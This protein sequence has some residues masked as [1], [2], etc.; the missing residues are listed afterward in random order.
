MFAALILISQVVSSSSQLSYFHRLDGEGH[1]VDESYV[2]CQADDGSCF[3]AGKVF[4]NPGSK[5]D[6]FVQKVSPTGKELWRKV[7][8]P[9]QSGGD[10]EYRAGHLSERFWRSDIPESIAQDHE[11]NVY[12]AGETTLDTSTKAMRSGRSAGTA[13]V[14]Y[15]TN[16]RLRFAKSFDDQANPKIA[17][18]KAG[19]VIM[20]CESGCTKAYLKQRNGGLTLEVRS[21]STTDG[22]EIS[23]L[24]FGQDSP[25]VAIRALNDGT[26]TL[27]AAAGP[28]FDNTEFL[29]KKGSPRNPTAWRRYTFDSKMA[30][31]SK[32]EFDNSKDL[33]RGKAAISPNGDIFCLDGRPDGSDS[34]TCWI[35]DKLAWRQTL[36]SQRIRY[37][38]PAD[39]DG[40]YHYLHDRLQ[41]GKLER[42]ISANSETVFVA[43]GPNKSTGTVWQV[44]AEAFRI[45]SGQPFGMYRHTLTTKSGESFVLGMV[46]ASDSSLLVGGKIGNDATPNVD[47]WYGAFSLIPSK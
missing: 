46:V 29:Y 38:N 30:V 13:L 36:A 4:S 12:I 6:F 43:G 31:V 11:G 41:I 14:S 24:V 27:V 47:A 16:G 35:H 22:R 25:P 26:V 19:T 17:I 3:F 7:Y 45:S 1:N 39:L 20:A 21:F 5:F 33:I 8:G 34:L 44:C 9:V 42:G 2:A 10:T 23:K 37:V 18:S 28:W 15:D 40:E 32:R